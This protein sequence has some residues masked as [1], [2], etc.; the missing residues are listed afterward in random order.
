[1]LG[2]AGGAY[3]GV[4][5]VLAAVREA[6]RSGR[7]QVVDTAIVDGVSLLTQMV[8]SYKQRGEWIDERE[9]NLF[10]GGAPFYGTFTCA[11]GEYM[12]VAAVEPQFYANLLQGL[13]LA[14][15]DL[16]EQYDQEGWPVL[17][18]RITEAFAERPR[19][20]WARV[21]AGLDACAT[22]VL[23]FR[24]AAEHPQITARGTLI[25]PGGVTQGAPAPRFSATPAVAP[26]PYG[27]PEPADAVLA[28]WRGQQ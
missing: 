7:G 21:F 14:G 22:P 10:D 28:Q 6:E 27:D 18:K 4:I 25:H 26:R 13:G 16:P 15:E 11:D 24:E 23:H 5:G 9:S 1:M 20:E 19:D 12:A 2:F 3:M 8:W 17:R